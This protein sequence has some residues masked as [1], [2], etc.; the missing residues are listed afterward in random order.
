MHRIA[1]HLSTDLVGA[2]GVWEPNFVAT[3]NSVITRSVCS[4]EVASFVHGINS[5]SSIQPSALVV[6]NQETAS[7]GNQKTASLS[8][9]TAASVGHWETAT[10]EA[11]SID[12]DGTNDTAVV[13]DQLETASIGTGFISKGSTPAFASDSNQESAPS[14]ADP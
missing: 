11:M 12:L 4:L 5:T 2:V 1:T 6:L 7:I 13:G 8:M 10:C 9:F 14:S 3:N